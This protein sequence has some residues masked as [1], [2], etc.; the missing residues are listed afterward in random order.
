[1]TTVFHTRPYGRCIDILDNLRRKK[2]HRTNQGSNSL[3]GGFS[4]RDN[5]RVPTNLE[6]KVNPSIF[7]SRTDPSIFTVIV[8]VLL[9]QSNETS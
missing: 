3:G 2:L 5:I 4:N 7:F 1:M 6:E 8:P 9:N